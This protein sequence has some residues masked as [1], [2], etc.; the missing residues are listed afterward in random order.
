MAMLYP[1]IPCYGKVT[2]W[3]AQVTGGVLIYYHSFIRFYLFSFVFNSTE[4]V[5]VSFL[6]SIYNLVPLCQG[7]T[8][9]HGFILISLEQNSLLVTLLE[10]SSFVIKKL[11]KTFWPAQKKGACLFSD[12]VSLTID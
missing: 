5:T 8:G 1:V 3:S 9:A 7:Y 2:V 6:G 4:T 10:T 11:E 12:Q